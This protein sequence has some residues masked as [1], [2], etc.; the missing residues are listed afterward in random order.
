[1]SALLGL[2]GASGEQQNQYAPDLNEID[3]ITGSVV[4]AQFANAIAK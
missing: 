2:L 1:M 4:V 3:S